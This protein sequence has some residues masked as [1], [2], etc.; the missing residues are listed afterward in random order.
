M[1]L[2]RCCGNVLEDEKF[3]SE[4]S[5]ADGKKRY[6]EFCSDCIMNNKSKDEDNIKKNKEKMEDYIY[7][8][9]MIE[10]LRTSG[11]AY[12][13]KR[14]FSL[15]EIEKDLGKKVNVRDSDYGGYIIYVEK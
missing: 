9:K 5:Y 15:E 4:Y 7:Y 2:C 13:N 11:K 10:N 6:S 3:V 1:R 8:K 14:K 12:I